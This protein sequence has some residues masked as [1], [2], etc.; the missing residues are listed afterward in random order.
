MLCNLCINKLITNDKINSKRKRL[1][2]PNRNQAKPLKQPLPARKTPN[3]MLNRKNKNALKQPTADNLTNKCPVFF[4][5]L[6][7]FINIR[8]LLEV[9][10]K[11]LCRQIEML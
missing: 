9:E 5:F 7:Y 1:N 3:F 8:N 6:L 11:S 4:Y 2:T 10:N